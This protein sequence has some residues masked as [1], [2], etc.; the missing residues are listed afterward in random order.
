MERT[1]TNFSSESPCPTL[2]KGRSVAA[3]TSYDFGPSGVIG[4]LTPATWK[5]DEGLPDSFAASWAQAIIE[6]HRMTWAECHEPTWG[7][8]Y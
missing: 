6:V 2:S 8:Q 3:W 7:K 4:D 1:V 5:R